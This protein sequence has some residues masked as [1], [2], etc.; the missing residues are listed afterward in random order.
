M[1]TKELKLAKGPFICTVHHISTGEEVY[2]EDILSPYP[3]TEGYY[4]VNRNNYHKFASFEELC[5]VVNEGLVK[6]RAQWEAS[7]EDNSPI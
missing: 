4:L 3:R 7:N 2:E 5:A 1:K 6:L